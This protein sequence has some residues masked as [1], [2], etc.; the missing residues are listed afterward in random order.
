M[1]M[2]LVIL[3][4]HDRAVD[5]FMTPMFMQ[6]IGQAVRSFTDEVNRPAEDNILYKHPEDYDLF[7]LGTFDSNTGK[8]DMRE[9]PR[10]VAIGKDLQR[11]LN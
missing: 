8:F 5:A 1:K 2:K 7:E 3:A 9:D 4:V 11:T 6:S 10:Q